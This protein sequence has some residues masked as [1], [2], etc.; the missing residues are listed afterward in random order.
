MLQ[1]IL[2]KMAAS[3][4]MESFPMDL[5]QEAAIL[6]RSSEVDVFRCVSAHRIVTQ[7]VKCVAM[8]FGTSPAILS[9]IVVF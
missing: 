7:S 4:F 6:S 2:L 9:T 8:S 3:C 1:K 5:R